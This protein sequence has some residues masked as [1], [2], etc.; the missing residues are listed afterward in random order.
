MVDR[1]ECISGLG[2]IPEDPM[3]ILQ[4]SQG[5]RRKEEKEQGDKP[6]SRVYL[7]SISHAG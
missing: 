3:S 7:G 1:S 2:A 6:C 5:C 4:L